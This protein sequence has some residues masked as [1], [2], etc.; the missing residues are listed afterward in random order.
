MIYYIRCISLFLVVSFV[1]SCESDFDVNADWE[2][3][4]I[5]YGILDAGKDTNFIRINKAFL[6]DENALIM[7]NVSDSFN[8]NPNEISVLLYELNNGQEF[9][10]DSLK[11]FVAGMDQGVFNN[12]NNIVYYTNKNLN[13]NY[14]YKLTINKPNGEQVN[15]TTDIVE[16]N[17]II[18]GSGS[19]VRFF[20]NI[21]EQYRNYFVRCYPVTNGFLYEIFF[22]FHYKEWD[23]QS[24]DTISKFIE[25]RII[26]EENPNNSID[27]FVLGERFFEK[28]SSL[29][30]ENSN[31]YRKAKYVEIIYSVA[32]EELSNFIQVNSPN[33]SL[34][35]EQPVY[36]NIENGLGVFSSSFNYSSIKYLHGDTY[37]RITTDSLTAYLNFVSE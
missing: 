29:I 15:V 6:G 18:D 27:E 20:D 3:I 4:T 7:A 19:T 21:T 26:N 17:S 32:T 35:L 24:L 9:F 12:N 23:F 36:S 33:Q 11:Y 30:E 8:Y 31:K 28:L 1:F 34:L 14:S 5:V 16:A 25:W 22:R 2:D 13:Y 10:F 37:N